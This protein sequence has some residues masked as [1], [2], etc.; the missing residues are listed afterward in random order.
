MSETRHGLIKDMTGQR[1]GRLTVKSLIPREGK[2]RRKWL[3]ICDCGNERKV[4]RES[5]VTGYTSSCG[6][7]SREKRIEALT[8]HGKAETDE[9]GIWAGIKTRCF[10]NKTRAYP[11]YGGRGITMCEDWRNDFSTFLRDMGKRPSKEHS[12]ERRDVDGN[13]EPSNCY[14]ATWDEQA[15]NRRTRKHNQTGQTGVYIT[16]Q[17]TYSARINVGSHQINLGC[18]RELDAAVRARKAAEIKYW[19]RDE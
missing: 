17:G 6:C 11:Y 13:Y 2:K 15:R 10:N 4:I 8:T 7:Y 18:Y 9:Y 16:K 5:L 14:W 3:C 1:F 19:G 12:V